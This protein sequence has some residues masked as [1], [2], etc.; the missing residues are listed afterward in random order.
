MPEKIKLPAKNPNACKKH[1]VKNQNT[2]K[3]SKHLQCWTKLHAV[4]PLI[5]SPEQYSIPLCWHPGIVTITNTTTIVVI[6]IIICTWSLVFIPIVTIALSCWCCWQGES[7]RCKERDGL[8]W[9]SINVSFPRLQ[10]LPT[11]DLHHLC[12]PSLPPP[13][14]KNQTNFSKNSSKIQ[15]PTFNST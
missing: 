3:K 13:V 12:N 11:Q 15:K 9:N 4:K 6:I 8:D 7:K 5:S 10:E 2:W 14:P 1:L